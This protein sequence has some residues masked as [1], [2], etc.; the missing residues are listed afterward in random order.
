MVGLVST[1]YVIYGT[2]NRRLALWFAHYSVSD[3]SL[4]HSLTHFTHSLTHSL[5]QV[6]SS[7]V[8]SSHLA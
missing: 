1:A 5:T 8:K 7:Q 6:K 3:H 2:P 4:T